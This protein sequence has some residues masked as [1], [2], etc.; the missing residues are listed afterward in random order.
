MRWSPLAC[1]AAAPARLRAQRRARASR[2]T[3]RGALRRPNDPMRE[4]ARRRTPGIGAL[5]VPRASLRVPR[6]SPGTPRGALHVPSGPMREVARRRTCCISALRMPR[7][8]LG[9]PRVSLGV[10]SV[11]PRK[12]G[13]AEANRTPLPP[14]PSGP[15]ASPAPPVRAPR[16]RG[17]EGELG[18]TFR[19]TGTVGQRDASGVDPA[20]VPRG[21]GPPRRVNS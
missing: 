8:S 7:A 12:S 21:S 17:R 5:R 14:S 13:G 11:T 15:G 18:R 16:A 6:A 19:S 1:T 4:V 2:R 9:V 3:P 10:P 20:I